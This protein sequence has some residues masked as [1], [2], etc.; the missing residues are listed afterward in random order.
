MNPV[1]VRM[2]YVIMRTLKANRKGIVTNLSNKE[3]WEA[4][5]KACKENTLLEQHG[6]TGLGVERLLPP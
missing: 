3:A 2:L 6:E 5:L 1:H 4:G